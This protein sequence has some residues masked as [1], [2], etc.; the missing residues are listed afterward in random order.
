MW[1]QHAWGDDDKQGNKHTYR[2]VSAPS[3]VEKI[4]SVA[5][6]MGDL[7]QRSETPSPGE[8][9]S[10]LRCHSEKEPVCVR[11]KKARI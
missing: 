10:D 7:A 2:I 8:V 3:A 11:R 6:G 1:T 5:R 9:T 4:E